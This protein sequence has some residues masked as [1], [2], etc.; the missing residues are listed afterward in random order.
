MSNLHNSPLHPNDIS[1][2]E[3]RNYNKN[4]TARCFTP[5]L[6]QFVESLATEFHQQHNLIRCSKSSKKHSRTLL[7]VSIRISPT[8]TAEKA[9]I[10]CFVSSSS[11]TLSLVYHRHPHSQPSQRLLVWLAQSQSQVLEWNFYEVGNSFTATF[12]AFAREFHWEF[13]RAYKIWVNFRSSFDACSLIA[14]HSRV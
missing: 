8:K 14:T 11:L 9:S 7:K 5:T 13:I 6:R 3:T 2:Q 4:M 12:I 1:L 10:L